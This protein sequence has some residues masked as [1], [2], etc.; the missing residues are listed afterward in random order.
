MNS[1]AINMTINRFNSLAA[2]AEHSP[3]F[4]SRLPAPI[5][6][7][8]LQEAKALVDASGVADLLAVWVAEDGR[9]VRST[10]LPARQMLSVWI[11]LGL[12]HREL[13]VANAA[14]V[15]GEHLTPARR[16]ALD[17]T[18]DFST[19]RREKL[20]RIV[21]RAT[22]SLIAVMDA[23]PTLT[24]GRRLTKVEWEYVVA[25]RVNVSDDLE[26]RRKRFVVFA[27]RLVGA[28][29]KSAAVSD[30]QDGV[31]VVV[32][33]RFRSAGV[34]GVGRRQMNALPDTGRVSL[35]PD[36]GY[37]IQNPTVADRQARFGWEDELAVLISND[38]DQPRAVPNIVIGFNPHLPGSD[39]ATA[40]AEVLHD[41]AGRENA[42]DHVV[43]DRAY[44]STRPE[45]L[46]NPLMNLDVKL[47]A[48]YPVSRLGVQAASGSGILVDGTWYAPSLPA[49]LQDA[50]R[51]FAAA[52]DGASLSAKADAVGEL[53]TAV[54]DRAA[55]SR[56]N[57]HVPGVAAEQ[58]DEQY[59]P[60]RSAQWSKVYGMGRSAF[61]AYADA[62]ARTAH[63][64]PGHRRMRGATA[65][66]FL[67]VLNVIGTNARVL[68]DFRA[69][70]EEPQKRASRSPLL[71]R[72]FATSQLVARTEACGSQPPRRRAMA[73]RTVGP[74]SHE[75]CNR[76]DDGI[77]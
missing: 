66:A 75:R 7:A 29:H 54:A 41:V 67:S 72:V 65:Q 53:N 37:W 8:T 2:T 56:R 28:Q 64:L 58:R 38:P 63:T 46:R 17:L 50:G 76:K 31:S 25:E 3:Q 73:W 14:A 6:T 61:E 39:F 70:L 35:E 30:P 71:N 16:R 4:G 77:S 1:S 51:A 59:Y 22:K 5:P 18:Q 11:A 62:L 68:E 27:N 19:H 15:L 48:D 43:L 45:G 13:T 57:P 21:D 10:S 44:M 69:A 33:S 20:E 23:F 34:R 49:R 36:A 55:F 24:R 40:A 9:K 60:Y 32:D 52:I 74:T 26:R 47:V 12:A 42:V